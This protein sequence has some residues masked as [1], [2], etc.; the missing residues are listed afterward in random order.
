MLPAFCSLFST[1]KF[2]FPWGL[3]SQYWLLVILSH[4]R[5]YLKLSKHGEVVSIFIILNT[6]ILIHMKIL[7]HQTYNHPEAKSMK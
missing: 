6:D 5:P 3:N 4:I 1:A 2:N 7:S